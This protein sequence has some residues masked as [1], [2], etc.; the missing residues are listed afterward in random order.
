MFSLIDVVEFIESGLSTYQY[1]AAVN[2]GTILC[3]GCEMD[4][5]DATFEYSYANSGGTFFFDNAVVVDLASFTLTNSWAFGDGGALAVDQ[6]ALGTLSTVTIDISSCNELTSIYAGSEGGFAF[7][8]SPSLEFTFSGCTLSGV[9][10]YD[11]APT[12]GGVA[13]DYDC[14][15]IDY[16]DYED[17]TCAD[18]WGGAFTIKEATS[19]TLTSM[20]ITETDARNSTIMYSVSD[21]VAITMTDSV[22]LCNSAFAAYAA[23]TDEWLD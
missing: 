17:G 20:T 19:F 14:N 6:S 23:A 21:K 22:F 13:V 8:Q 1:N 2:G 16:D 10:A 3:D 11:M 5:D 18:T 12:Q 15:D 7:L 4:V 9:S